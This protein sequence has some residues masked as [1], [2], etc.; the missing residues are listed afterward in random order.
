MILEEY[1]H[2]KERGAKIL[3]ELVGYG[4]TADGYH[5][6]S[7]D[8][9]GDGDARAF[10]MAMRHAGI[11]PE[12]LDY[13]NAH[14]TSTPLND[15]FETC[16]IKSALGDAARTVAVSSTKGTTGHALGAAGALE[17]IACVQ[18]LENQVIPPTINY[19]TPDPE[20]DLNIT[21][22]TAVERSVRYAANNNLGFGGHNAVVI[23]K[24]FED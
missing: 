20:C 24:K 7:P 10:Q 21:P 6:T 3:A 14:G 22:N 8:P 1:E 17:C 2:A 19:E 11:G 4:A 13:I 23:F 16:A 12:E 18:T 5:I 15:K 9:Q